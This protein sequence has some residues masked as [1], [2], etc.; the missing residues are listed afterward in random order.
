MLAHIKAVFSAS[1]IDSG[2][3]LDIRKYMGH[4]VERRHDESIRVQ[5]V[6]PRN[7][8]T[9]QSRCGTPRIR[10][11]GIAVRSSLA[12]LAGCFTAFSMT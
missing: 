9:K 11:L 5:P 1:S 7:E 4:A 10:L 8:V 2:R 12:G 3:L 6:I